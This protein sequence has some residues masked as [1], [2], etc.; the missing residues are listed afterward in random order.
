MKEVSKRRGKHR[1]SL[2]CPA[3]SQITKDDASHHQQKA[4][5]R[6]VHSESIHNDEIS[7]K[8]SVNDGSD[9]CELCTTRQIECHLGNK[10]HANDQDELELDQINML[11]QEIEDQET[12]QLPHNKN[13]GR[14][15]SFQ[16]SKEFLEALDVLSVNKQFFLRIL[17]D[18]GPS[19]RQHFLNQQAATV[20]CTKRKALTKSV[21]FPSSEPSSSSSPSPNLLSQK[22]KSFSKE[23]NFEQA[24]NDGG[25]VGKK[26]KDLGQ[27]IK[28]LIRESR[29]ERRR[30]AMDAV[31]HKVP[32]GKKVSEE[33]IKDSARI[34]MSEND[35]SFSPNHTKDGK[36]FKKQLPSLD[37]SI[38]KYRHLLLSTSFNR[39][40]PKINSPERSR[41]RVTDENSSKH[42]RKDLRRILSSPDL[43]ESLGHQYDDPSGHNSSRI[44]N[45]R[46]TSFNEHKAQDVST[47]N[48]KREKI[49]GLEICKTKQEKQK[50]EEDMASHDDIG[51]NIKE[52]NDQAIADKNALV[53]SNNSIGVTTSPDIIDSNVTTDVLVHEKISEG[54]CTS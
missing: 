34:S 18:P 20:A 48:L 47:M 35:M 27:K 26:F 2:T 32:Y 46:V 22:Q 54:M 16:H 1:R 23:D 25:V 7:I 4:T 15:V 14:S 40:D 38:D 41:L 43:H 31:L 39:A 30:I 9:K 6:R 12:D 21:T 42:A 17:D 10:K 52:Q 8:N 28:H 19:L 29:K 45:R 33:S 37:Q 44:P 50:T 11:F 24:K 53:A 3:G 36:D 5:D 13:L 51:N 49:D